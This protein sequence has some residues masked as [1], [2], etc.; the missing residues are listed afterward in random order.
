MIPFD[1]ANRDTACSILIDTAYQKWRSD[2]SCIQPGDCI[3]N[4]SLLIPALWI[5]LILL[6]Q[7]HDT[8]LLIRY[9][10]FVIH[11]DTQLIQLIQYQP[12]DVRCV[13]DTPWYVM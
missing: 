1:T 12:V 10:T 13:R 6:I 8:L 7:S 11:Y 2:H 5:S 4:F 3:K 9:D